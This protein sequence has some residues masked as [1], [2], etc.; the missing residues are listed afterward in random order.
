MPVLD[1]ATAASF[2]GILRA[3]HNN[4][5]NIASSTG[6]ASLSSSTTPAEDFLAETVEL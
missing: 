5:P 1:N 3:I 2:Y 4:L 6:V